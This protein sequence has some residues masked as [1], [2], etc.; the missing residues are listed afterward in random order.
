[1]NSGLAN[2]M[3]LLLNK[4][5]NR[6]GLK[7]LNLKDDL[8]KE[9]WADTVIVP[10]TLVTFSR[11]YPHMI[12]YHV[13][14]YTP[15][16]KGYYEID[17]EILGGC[18]ILGIKDLNWDDFGRDSF[19]LQQNA[20]YGMYDFLTQ[21]YGVSDIGILQMNADQMSLFNNGIYIDFQYPN[22][23][24]LVSVTG[25]TLGSSYTRFPIHIFV[26]HSPNLLTISP[27][28][29]E[30]F[31]ELAISDVAGYIYRN[32]KYYEGAETVYANISLKLEELEAAAGKRDE[33]LNYIKESYVSASNKNQPYLYC[34]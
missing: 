4:I 32:L 6:L 30:T 21:N 28:Q 20:G 29:M 16:V 12:E 9:N 33:I 34:V 10:D 22:R 14:E 7:P 24:K 17:E 3:T 5:E 31:E 18:K 26:E 11:Y 2:N 15:I 1:M 19:S 23:F 13:N 25:R 27:T 8:A